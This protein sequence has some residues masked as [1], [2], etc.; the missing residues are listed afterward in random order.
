[1]FHWLCMTSR[2]KYFMMVDQDFYV[3]C[4]VQYN[5]FVV[6]TACLIEI[7]YTHVTY[8]ARVAQCILIK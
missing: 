8:T 7:Y 6:G 3:G 4:A 5:A 1:M 2:C